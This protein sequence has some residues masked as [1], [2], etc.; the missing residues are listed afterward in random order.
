MN[1]C[2]I[3]ILFLLCIIYDNHSACPFLYRMA[4]RIAVLWEQNSYRDND[5]TNVQQTTDR[6]PSMVGRWI[7]LFTDYHI[8]SV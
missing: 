6:L 4:A 1:R 8:Y 5:S 3:I 7:I 2:K